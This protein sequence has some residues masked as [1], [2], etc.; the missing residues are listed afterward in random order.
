MPALLMPRPA[1]PPAPAGHG[2]PRSHGPPEH[3]VKATWLTLPYCGAPSPNNSPDRFLRVPAGNAKTPDE[4][5]RRRNPGE[6]GDHE[7]AG[8]PDRRR[9]GERRLR[10][11]E[12]PLRKLTGHPH[13][14]PGAAAERG[15]GR[16][17]P[18]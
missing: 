3:E 5:E 18:A 16:R 10:H 2:F 15:P 14:R 6:F 7:V 17:G 12:L 13:G 4:P 9:A 1:A 11:P 8:E